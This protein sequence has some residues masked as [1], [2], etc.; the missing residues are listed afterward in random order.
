MVDHH[1]NTSTPCHHIIQHVITICHQLFFSISTQH[2]ITSHRHINIF[3]FEPCSVLK[4]TRFVLTPPSFTFG[5]LCLFSMT[6]P[7]NQQITLF[8]ASS[9]Q[10]SQSASQSIKTTNQSSLCV[11]IHYTSHFNTASTSFTQ[12][13][14]TAG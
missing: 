9:S 5:S 2:V 11:T 8:S 1:I 6:C 4:H 14:F 13:G 12:Y 3:E 10:A 7:N